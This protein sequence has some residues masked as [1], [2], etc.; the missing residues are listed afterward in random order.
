[1]TTHYDKLYDHIY[2]DNSI[3]VYIV[4]EYV[5]NYQIT[6]QEG[7]ICWLKNNTVMTK[8]ISQLQPMDNT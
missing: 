1:V 4:N 8:M 2:I 7:R 6:S 5:R 3:I